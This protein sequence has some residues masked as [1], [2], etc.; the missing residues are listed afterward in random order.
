[1]SNNNFIPIQ[2]M[3]PFVEGD[4]DGTLERDGE[5][6]LD[7]DAADEN[8]TS[9]EADRLAAERAAEDAGED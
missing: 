8:L 1:M 5:A 3:V 9:A 7:P 6:A 2:P 4:L